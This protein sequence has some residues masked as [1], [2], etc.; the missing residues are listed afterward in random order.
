[1]W[2]MA[3]NNNDVLLTK[4][5]KSCFIKIA[6]FRIYGC[7]A[8]TETDRKISSFLLSTCSTCT[9]CVALKLVALFC[10]DDV[11]S[12]MYMIPWNSVRYHIEGLTKAKTFAIHCL[13]QKILELVKI[14]LL[15]WAEN[16]NCD[17][18]DS[19]IFACSVPWFEFLLSQN[20][21][22]KL[23]Y[24]VW[25]PSPASKQMLDLLGWNQV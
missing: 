11:L 25:T 24:Q 14:P 19:R 16:R 5:C 13:L 22:R 2:G 21:T 15:A 1:M 23:C 9:A 8:C 17:F 20:T 3:Y 12:S 18:V 4:K 7:S 6:P 10:H